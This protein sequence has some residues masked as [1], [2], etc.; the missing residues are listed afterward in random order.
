MEAYPGWGR[1]EKICLAD[2]VMNFHYFLPV[3]QTYEEPANHHLFYRC[4]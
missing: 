4:L 2:W 1:M 3:N